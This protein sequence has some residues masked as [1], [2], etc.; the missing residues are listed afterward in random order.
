MRYRP[1]GRSGRSVSELTLN[2]SGR[3]TARGKTSGPALVTEA[4]EHGINSFHLETPDP[5][6]GELVGRA[7]AG[8]DRRLLFV[9]TRIGNLRRRGQLER[10]LTPAGVTAAIDELLMSSGLEHLDLVLLDQPGEDELSHATLTALKAQRA[11]GRILMLGVAGF[12]SVMDA[13]VSTNAFDTLATPF[14][15]HSDWATRNR[16]RAAVDRDMAVFGYDY[17]PDTLASLEQVESG[18]SAKRGLFGWRGGNTPM[19]DPYFK[20]VG[21][22]AFLH[23]T[24]NWTAEEIC[25]S[26]A[27]SEPTIASVIVDT[28]DS[29]HLSRLAD[30]PE[31]SMPPGLA[32]QIEMARVNM[33]VVRSA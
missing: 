20:G 4:M 22:F 1:F 17:F 13:Y 21:T 15:V 3:T 12:G 7:I 28:H 32:A 26:Y 18:G 6:L 19:Q 30:L 5:V 24:P 23:Q 33:A 31:R 29:N 2:L 11:A 16:I 8:V 27:L 9:A 14:N 25:L 10:D